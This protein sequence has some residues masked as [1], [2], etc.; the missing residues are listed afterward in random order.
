[1]KSKIDLNAAIACLKTEEEVR[2]FL[3]DLCTPQ[4]IRQF[5]ER[6]EIAQYLNAGELSY[7]DIAA[8]VGA[9]T[10]TV[11]RVNRFLNQEPHQG[12]KLVLGRLA[13]KGK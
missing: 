7:R 10:T 4:E 6:W 8:K 13:G 9:S 3:V 5:E 12:Y 11:A 1:M 2:R